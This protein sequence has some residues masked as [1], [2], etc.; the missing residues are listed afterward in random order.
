MFKIKE[1]RNLEQSF[2][3]K[4]VQEELFKWSISNKSFA[5][6]VEKAKE[7]LTTAIPHKVIQQDLDV[8]LPRLF[9]L[10]SCHSVNLPLVSI[11]GKYNYLIKA[12]DSHAKAKLLGSI[13]AVLQQLNLYEIS[14]G[15][16]VLMIKS[17]I[18]LPPKLSKMLANTMFPLPM[19]MPPKHITKNT[20]SGYI[21]LKHSV[22]CGKRNKPNTKIALDVV[23]TQNAI[24]LTLNTWLLDNYTEVPNKPLFGNSLIDFNIFKLESK[25]VTSLINKEF[26]TFYLTHKLDSRGRLYS[27]GYHIN[28]QGI[29]YKKA[30]VELA[31]K[32]LV[33]GVPT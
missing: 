11:L 23:N 9:V 1:Q 32:E 25:Q 13:L 22:L 7:I 27:H 21:T 4:Y 24:P 14:W 16:D 18:V 8:L 3:I 20:Q 6:L 26:K 29:T 5:N 2:D 17:L 19:G 31:H 12:S 33:S 10:L 15:R 28:Y 30:C